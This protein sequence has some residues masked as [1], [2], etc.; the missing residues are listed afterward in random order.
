MKNLKKKSSERKENGWAEEKI[1]KPSRLQWW[2][3]RNT[4]KYTLIYTRLHFKVEFV[5][6]S[7]KL[8]GWD[9]D[10]WWSYYHSYNVFIIQS[11]ASKMLTND[12]ESII[13]GL[14]WSFFLS[15]SLI[16]LWCEGE[17]K[18]RRLN[19]FGWLFHNFFL[20]FEVF[21]FQF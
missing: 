2:W 16:E 13:L 14:L 20:P 15:T 4:C 3:A 11:E 9:V 8:M 12:T 17:S 21:P 1:T 5:D 18:K 6:S 10:P 7:L 19:A